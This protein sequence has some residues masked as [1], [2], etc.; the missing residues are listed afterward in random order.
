MNLQIHHVIGAKLR[1]PHIEADADTIRKSLEEENTLPLFSE[2]GRDMSNWPT[3]AHFI[4]W[5][6]LC[7]DNDISGGK[8][9]W[10]GARK[11]KNRAGHLFRL[12]AGG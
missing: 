6:A 7:P 5:L 10:R 9:L 2:I 3:A 12:A 11:V 4:S 1:D 8:L